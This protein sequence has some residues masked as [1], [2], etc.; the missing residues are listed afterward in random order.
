MKSVIFLL[1]FILSI[2][3]QCIAQ[4]VNSNVDIQWGNEFNES[5]NSTPNSVVGYDETGFYVMSDKHSMGSSYSADKV[6]IS[7]F[8]SNAK[9]IK[10]AELILKLDKKDMD[11]EYMIQLNGEFYVFS[12]F[13]N[14]KEKKKSLYVQTMNKKTLQINSESR[15]IAEGSFFRKSDAW[16]ID[17]NY[18]LS[19]DSS[20]IIVYHRVLTKEAELSKYR[21]YIFDNK[22]NDLWTRE[23]EIPYIYSLFYF[24]DYILDDFGNLHFLVKRLIKKKNSGKKEEYDN[25]YYVLSYYEDR[26]KDSVV[27]IDKKGKFIKNIRMDINLSKALIITGFYC[28]TEEYGEDGLFYLKMDLKTKNVFVENFKEFGQDFILE[29]RIELAVK[30]TKEYPE[31]VDYILYNF[32][33]D[34][35][36]LKED[37]SAIVTGEQSYYRTVDNVNGFNDYGSRNIT[38]TRTYY[39]RN[40]IAINIDKE[41]SVLWME[42]IGKFQECASNERTLSSYMPLFIGDKMCF[43]F[44]D[45]P[46]NIETYGGNDAYENFRKKNSQIVIVEVDRNGIKEKSLLF[47]AGDDVVL[48]RPTICKQISDS[49]FVLYIENGEIEH[50]A[51]VTFK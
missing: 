45:H 11:F 32:E 26:T 40:I 25:A 4:K 14:K 38:S 16:K 37:G 44:N 12:S 34:N 24:K 31:G 39:Y 17:Y 1:I 41:G 51:K 18:L 9:L 27:E 42:T 33:I 29:N 49:T 35:I 30:K 46:D 21:Y 6:I 7:H 36:V 50:F 19:R 20:K 28:N 43:I 10:E 23:I 3:T 15:K 47:S 22:M 2:S 5:N 48:T 8:G 13:V